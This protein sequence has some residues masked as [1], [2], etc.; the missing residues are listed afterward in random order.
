MSAPLTTVTEP[1]WAV[2]S[3]VALSDVEWLSCAEVRRTESPTAAGIH[4]AL[5][6]VRGVRREAPVS[7]RT[8]RPVAAPLVRSELIAAM[9]AGAPD[10]DLLS[11]SRLL[12][13]TTR[14]V[15]FRPSVATDP[16]YVLAV[17]HALKWVMGEG[18][19]RCPYR[20]PVRNADGSPRTADE[21]YRAA[22]VA[23]PGYAT[24]PESRQRLRNEAETEARVSRQLA[25]TIAGA[26]AGHGT[27]TLSARSDR[28]S[29]DGVFRRG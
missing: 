17:W 15:P 10:G 13:R 19:E 4:A 18:G 5:C 7:E 29:G 21:L 14:E 16:R 28:G 11:G 12:E 23:H 9:I 6:W 27:R 20:L 8:E 24:V 26:Q 1:A 3:A 25:D 22:L 2:P